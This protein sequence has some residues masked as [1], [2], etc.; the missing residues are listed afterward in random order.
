MIRAERINK[1][2]E[3]NKWKA[4]NGNG[5]RVLLHFKICRCNVTRTSTYIYIY[6]LRQPP[7]VSLIFKIPRMHCG[8]FK[9]L[10]VI[11][12]RSFVN[13][14]FAG[15]TPRSRSNS[16]GRGEKSRDMT[17]SR[18]RSHLDIDGVKR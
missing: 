3:K 17:V 12:Y 18:A 10:A 4:R 6:I 8:L 2:R 9:C 15:N 13:T 11:V 16:H 1:S 5:A 14:R 7:K